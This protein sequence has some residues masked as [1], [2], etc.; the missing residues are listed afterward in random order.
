MKKMF[1]LIVAVSIIAAMLPSSAAAATIGGDQGWINVHCNIDGAS[2]YFDGEYKGEI[3]QG[4]YTQ[5]IYST[6]TPYKTVSVEKAGYTTW[7]ED[8]N[9]NPGMG[10]TMDVYATLN[11]IPTPEPTMIGGSTGYYDVYCNIDGADVYFNSDYKGQIANGEL[12]VEVY[13][14]GTPYTTYTVSKTGYTT[15]SAQ[16]TDYPAAGETVK[17][18][19]T[20]VPSSEPTPTQGSP[21][22]AFTILGALVFG[23]V[24]FALIA[25]RD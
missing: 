14:T 17:L 3:V 7:S 6:G 18:H 25:K 13:V 8:L 10:E 2:V 24:G 15:F 22:S 4:I 5:A 1:V 9:T 19:A 16:I 21:V 23:L 11:L 20:L 12:N